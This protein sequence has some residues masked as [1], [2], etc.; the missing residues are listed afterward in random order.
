[1]EYKKLSE[2]ADI[3]TGARISRFN[4]LNTKKQAV[5]KKIYSNNEFDY[6]LEEISEDL[7]QKF[8][9]KRNDI[10]ISLTNPHTVIKVNKE[11]YIVP[12]TYIIVRVKSDYDAEYIYQILKN[13]IIP[14]KI[15][16]LIE[17]SILKTIRVIY[18]KEINIPIIDFEKQKK[19]V[20]LLSLFEKRRKLCQRSIELTK[21]LEKGVFDKFLD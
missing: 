1:M 13:E 10:L 11:G 4:T 21:E 5:I 8:Y 9:T 16:R 14:K 2:V 3:L 17:G 6:E 20:K 18:L 15:N 19:M 12:M 7:D